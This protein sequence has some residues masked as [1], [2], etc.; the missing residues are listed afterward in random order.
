M[1]CDSTGARCS[2]SGQGDEVANQLP[3]TPRL[4]K[5]LEQ[6]MQEAQMLNADQIATHHLLLG[7]LREEEGVANRVLLNLGGD[8]QHLRDLVLA[9]LDEAPPENPSPAQTLTRISRGT[10][11]A[12]S[13]SAAGA[14]PA[15]IC[16][17]CGERA[18]HLFAGFPPTAEEASIC[19]LC[20]DVFYATLSQQ[21]DTLN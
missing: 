2:A 15:E 20:I 10:D 16:S 5:V 18:S 9:G 11:P 14:S 13:P 8:A 19:D 3:F 17:F 6:G 12:A 7:L 21:R 4:K 1:R